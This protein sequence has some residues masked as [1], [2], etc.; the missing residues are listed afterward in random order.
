MHIPFDSYPRAVRK[1]NKY[2]LE[3][4]GSEHGNA[5]Y[6]WAW[7]GD[8]MM[9]TIMMDEES[10]VLY[11]FHCACGINASVHAATCNFSVPRAKWE[12]RNLLATVRNQWVLV[13]WRAPEADREAWEETFG[14]VPYPDGGYYMPV[15][16]KTECIHFPQ[17]PDRIMSQL[18]VSMVREHFSRTAKART[19]D[20]KDNWDRMDKERFMR[21][22]DRFKDA[23]PVHEGFPGKKENWSHGGVGE[24]PVLV[25]K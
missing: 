5:R 7:S 9:P 8:L 20:I 12:M 2:L 15:S 19:Q 13:K 24:S 10:K 25:T 17:A 14:S 23:F 4:L 1:E 21:N 22:V 6:S 11:D 16:T 18:I 3:A